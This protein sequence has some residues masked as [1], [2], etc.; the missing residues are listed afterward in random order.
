MQLI[1]CTAVVLSCFFVYSFGPH[2]P[3]MWESNNYFLLMTLHFFIKSTIKIVVVVV[4][5]SNAEKKNLDGSSCGAKDSQVFLQK[6]NKI[7]GS[8]MQPLK[9]LKPFEPTWPLRKQPWNSWNFIGPFARKTWESFVFKNFK[10][11]LDNLHPS[12][13]VRVVAL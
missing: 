6:T 10:V 4:C 12:A 1:V 11:W 3:A 8:T 2:G 13:P 5:C 9:T 7:R